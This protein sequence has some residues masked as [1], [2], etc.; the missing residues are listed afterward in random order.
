M[1]TCSDEK[2]AL[3]IGA[4]APDFSLPGTDGKTYSLA[5]FADKKALVVCISCNHCPYVQAAEDRMIA[6]QR[7]FGPKGVQLVCINPNDD[8]V[9]P[10][11]SFEGMKQRAK[12]RGFNFTYLRDESQAVARAYGA[13]CTPEFFVFD[14]DRKLAYHGRIDD[15]YK[16]AAK[17]RRHDLRD[18]AQ[19][20]LDGRAVAEPV[21][22]AMGCSIKWRSE[23]AGLHQIR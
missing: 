9:Y 10:E 1:A 7:D 4:R 18:A 14:K 15:G 8:T 3:K 19:A 16:D 13:Q 17:A 6:F 2:T 5:S 11:D 22:M 23:P 12:A 20:V 21:T